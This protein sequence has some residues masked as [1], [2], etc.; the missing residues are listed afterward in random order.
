MVTFSQVLSSRQ[1]SMVQALPSSQWASSEQMHVT[2]VFWQI[3]SGR[4]QV[5]MEHGLMSSQSPSVAHSPGGRTMDATIG[6]GEPAGEGRRKSRWRN[7][8]N[9]L[10]IL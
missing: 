9:L 7:T 4:M 3:P 5:S 2:G 1:E 8:K 10:K 6:I